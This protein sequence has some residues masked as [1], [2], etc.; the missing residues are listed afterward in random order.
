MRCLCLVAGSL[1][2]MSSAWCKGCASHP[3]HWP[4]HLVLVQPPTGHATSH[5]LCFVV[6][7]CA[8]HKVACPATSG[9]RGHSSGQPWSLDA[10]ASQMPYGVS[11]SG[12]AKLG[13]QPLGFYLYSSCS[14]P[15][16]SW[17]LTLVLH[18]CAFEGPPMPMCDN[19]LGVLLCPILSDSERVSRIWWWFQPQKNR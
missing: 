17:E 3:A 18:P 11:S 13:I 16:Y 7:P 6:A 4:C 1:P 10:T 5:M 2:Q 9:G 12:C 8:R 14:C 19:S 15:T